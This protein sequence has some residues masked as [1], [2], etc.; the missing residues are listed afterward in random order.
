M[1]QADAMRHHRI[2]KMPALVFQQIADAGQILDRLLRF[3][4]PVFG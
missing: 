2:V 4:S 1:D 3:R